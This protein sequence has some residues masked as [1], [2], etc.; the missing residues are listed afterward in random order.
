METLRFFWKRFSREANFLAYLLILGYVSRLYR[1][2][3]LIWIDFMWIGWI[4]VD[5]A[6]SAARA[7][8]TT[9][10]YMANNYHNLPPLY[11][12]RDGIIYTAPLAKEKKR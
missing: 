9:R 6:W 3:G 11:V 4:F 8:R 12:D 7:V 5:L 1:I 10:R 2:G